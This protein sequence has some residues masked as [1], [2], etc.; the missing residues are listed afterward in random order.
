MEENT[1]LPK[2]VVIPADKVAFMKESIEKLRATNNSDYKAGDFDSFNHKYEGRYNA[3]EEVL[4]WANPL[5]FYEEEK[6]I[7]LEEI[8]NLSKELQEKDA[9]LQDAKEKIKVLTY[10]NNRL[11]GQVEGLTSA[12]EELKTKYDNILATES[13]HESKTEN[14]WQSGY[15]AGHEAGS[16]RSKREAQPRAVWVK[17]APK[18]YKQYFAKVP[19]VIEDDTMYDAVIWPIEGCEHWWCVGYGFKFS[20]H[21]DKIIAHIDESAAGREDDRNE[22]AEWC[23]MQP[24]YGYV[25]GMGWMCSITHEYFTTDFMYELFKQQKEK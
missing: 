2:E 12:V 24:N 21:R 20:V 25:R 1:Q 17:G 6:E 8:T 11:K 10:D 9:Q 14:V 15:A 13:G 16:E 18:D 4:Q 23:R 5:R 22:F 19:S 3:F 7:L